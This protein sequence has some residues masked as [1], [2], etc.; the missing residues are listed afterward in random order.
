[1]LMSVKLPDLAQFYFT[2]DSIVIPAIALFILI[3]FGTVGV[4]TAV[5]AGSSV[6]TGSFD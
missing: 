2:V 6:V 3:A 5:I 4:T 1:M